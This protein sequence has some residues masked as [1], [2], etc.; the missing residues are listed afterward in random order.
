MFVA[1]API[2]RSDKSGPARGTI[3]MGRYLES[4]PLQR[5]TDMTG[6]SVSLELA[7]RGGSGK[8]VCPLQ[9]LLAGGA[10]SFL[11][12]TTRA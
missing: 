1:S 11:Q 8:P 12:Q 7:G 6:Y 5:I 10:I 2:L 9:E 3:I 4:G